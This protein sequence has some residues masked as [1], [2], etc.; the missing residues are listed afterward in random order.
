M[1]TFT[2]A[3]EME[4]W[5]QNQQL[6]GQEIGFV[7]TMGALHAGHIALVKQARTEN[8]RVVVSI[9]VNRLQFNNPEDFT[10]YP[11]QIGADTFLLEQAGC[12]ALFF[13][14]SHAEV[15]PHNDPQPIPL[16]GLDTYMEGPFRPGHFQGVAHVV[17]RLFEIVRPNRA[18]FGLKDYQQFLVIKHLSGLFFPDLQ[19]VGVET[20]REPNG[21]AMSSR[22]IRLTAE[23]QQQASLVARL[24]G[25]M[26]S[27]SETRSPAELK[28]W[29]H[30][31]VEHEPAIEMEYLEICS[32]TTLKPL[33]M[34]E[35]GEKARAFTA[36]YVNRVRLIDN[37]EIF[38]G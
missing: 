1:E 32:A 15:F 38:E 21:L 30:I 28:E 20:V 26:K 17:K 31:Q 7:P 37:L 23:Q 34:F 2:R 14:A 3:N 22:N 5:I 24:I 18:Y 4:R 10:N 27:L 9:F 12:D 35:P 33:E 29:F 8:Q 11:V 13:P 36:F 25:Q 6:Q 19:I 16:D